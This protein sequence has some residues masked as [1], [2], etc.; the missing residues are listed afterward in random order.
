MKGISLKFYAYEFQKYHGILLYEWLL[1]FAKKNGI[2]GGTAFR[3][4]AGFG[5]HSKLHE[6]HFFELAANI[7]IEVNFSLN[8]EEALRFLE[9]L[10]KEKLDLFYV[11]TEVE[12]GDLNDKYPT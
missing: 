2:R 11:K 8:E 7:P 6:E 3:G 1:E 9:L 4:I 10:K 5:R 12:Y